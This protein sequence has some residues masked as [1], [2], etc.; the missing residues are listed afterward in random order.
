MSR[1]GIEPVA[2]A[3]TSTRTYECVP[4]QS[5]LLATK[6]LF[7]SDFFV[8]QSTV[9]RNRLKNEKITINFK[10]KFN[11]CFYEN[12]FISCFHCPEYNY[13]FL[14]AVYIFFCGC[15]GMPYRAATLF[16]VSFFCNI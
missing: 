13:S 8:C 14:P 10:A 5:R 7:S 12:M 6:H 1:P 3:G 9:R 11:G 4:M 16:I 2:S 15:V